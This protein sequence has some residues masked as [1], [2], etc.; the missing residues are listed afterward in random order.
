MYV[1]PGKCLFKD[2][3]FSKTTK[4]LHDAVSHFNFLGLLINE[5]L[6]WQSHLTMVTNKPFKISG[7]PTEWKLSPNRSLPALLPI[8]KS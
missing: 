2:I 6:S 7:G 5:N 3:L 8:T 1:F 4:A